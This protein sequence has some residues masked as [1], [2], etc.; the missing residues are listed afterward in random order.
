VW[1]MGETVADRVTLVPA[2][3]AWHYLDDGS[4]QGDAWTGLEFDHSTWGYGQAELGYGDAQDGR[5]ESTLL[6]YGPDSGAKHITYY[7]RHVFTVDDRDEFAAL[8]IQL[9]RDDGGAVHLNGEA[10]FKSNLE[11]DPVTHLSRARLADD[12]GALFH[13]TSVGT[14]HLRS[15]VN[16]LAV[17]IHQ[18]SPTSSDVS[19][20]L[21]LEGERLP[22]LQLLRFGSEP[23]LFWSA[24]G[25]I[26]ETADRLGASWRTLELTSPG[27]ISI[28]TEQQFYRLRA[29]NSP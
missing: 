10:L 26:L 11:A 16:V 25:F 18:Q 13:P 15:G 2:G 20:D 14:S 4:N 5:P 23:F 28:G 6:S 27:A 7:F 19:F 12:D 1:Y 22:K 8:R 24:A 21:S 29:M 3:S 9:K 17:E